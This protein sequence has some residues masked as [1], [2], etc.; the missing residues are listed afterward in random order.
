MKKTDERKENETNSLR[1][2]IDHMRGRLQGRSMYV[3]VG[4]FVL[5]VALVALCLVLES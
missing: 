4:S 5:I 2:W 1:L 3:A